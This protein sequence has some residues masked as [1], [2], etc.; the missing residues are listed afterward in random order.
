[1]TL[2]L[3][4]DDESERD[5]EDEADGLERLGGVTGNRSGR[6]DNWRGRVA[7][8]W[9][10]RRSSRIAS[11]SGIACASRIA[12]AGRVAVSR[13]TSRIASRW[14]CHHTSRDVGRR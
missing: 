9:L 1:M 14:L 8:R 12:S 2:L 10:K 6:G 13:R 5:E 4:Y 11:S 7:S 3:S